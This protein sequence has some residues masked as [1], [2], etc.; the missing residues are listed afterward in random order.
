MEL[1]TFIC[2]WSNFS[3]T[4]TWS[5]STWEASVFH[6][7]E[8]DSERLKPSAYYLLVILCLEEIKFFFDPLTVLGDC[9]LKWLCLLRWSLKV[10]H[11]RKEEKKLMFGNCFIFPTTDNVEELSAKEWTRGEEQI[12]ILYSSHDAKST[13]QNE[14]MR[15]DARATILIVDQ[16]F[17]LLKLHIARKIVRSQRQK[18]VKKVEKNDERTKL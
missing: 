13:I 11:R 9:E 10:T 7:F 18:G 12:S 4:E 16:I 2:W 17:S 6:R 1:T 14:W 3:R 15:D 5:S 8:L